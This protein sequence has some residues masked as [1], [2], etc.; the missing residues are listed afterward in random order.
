MRPGYLSSAVVS[1]CFKMEAHDLR[2]AGEGTNLLCMAVF[3][4]RTL[5]WCLV[6]RG[7]QKL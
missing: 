5:P 3:L 2:S 6:S 1:S 4:S 7:F